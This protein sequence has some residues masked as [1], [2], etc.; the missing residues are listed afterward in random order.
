LPV[1]H[2]CAPSWDQ[3][4][5]AADQRTYLSC[6]VDLV[7]QVERA[8]DDLCSLASL[9]FALHEKGVR[10]AAICCQRASVICLKQRVE[11]GQ[12]L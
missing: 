3:A 2:V 6:L 4:T 11:I 9:G 8:S 10:Q 1:G 5:S 12:K 7:R